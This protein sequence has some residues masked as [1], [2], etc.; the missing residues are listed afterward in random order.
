MILISYPS[1]GFG[2]F[3]FHVLTEFADNTY[4]PDNTNFRFDLAGRSHDTKK[5][6][7]TYFHEPSEYNTLLPA[8]DKECLVLCDNGIVNDSY[9]KVSQVFPNAVIVRACID[10][11]VRPVIFKTCVVKAQKSD[12][13]TETNEHVVTHWED[14]EDYS[15]REN[16]TLLYHNWHFKWTPNERCIN[17][18]IEQLIN[19]PVNTIVKLINSI[20]GNAIDIERL[21]QL[22][23][24]W[25]V[26]NQSYF[27]IYYDWQRINK[28]LDQNKSI[29]LTDITD[30]HDQGYINYC[31]EKK[32]NYT[33]P[34][35]DYKN[36]FRNTSEV[37]RHL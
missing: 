14:T 37:P 13:L 10:Q 33:I 7:T 34:V 21:K 19:D 3:L 2:N 24:E 32:F 31:L 11:A 15:I 4:K 28:A 20:E 8:T 6:T 23:D 18:S 17:V 1:G 26:S 16:F 9:D 30:L 29:E 22:C 12:T 35:F 27:K 36:W 5:Y 25:T